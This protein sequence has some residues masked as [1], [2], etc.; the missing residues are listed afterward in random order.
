MTDPLSMLRMLS[1][2][3]TLREAFVEN[4]LGR[5]RGGVA[6]CVVCVAAVVQSGPCEM[7]CGSN[8]RNVVDVRKLFP[9]K[10]RTKR[11]MAL[12]W[13][14]FFFMMMMM[15]MSSSC[16]AGVCLRQGCSSKAVVAILMSNIHFQ[17][18]YNNC[19][20]VVSY[21]FERKN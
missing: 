17:R 2:L 1:P 16:H 18:S 21:Y 20:N 13:R 11:S 3:A 5:C 19:Q 4:L 7:S 14:C 15:M 8:P 10:S 12:V 6:V 9:S